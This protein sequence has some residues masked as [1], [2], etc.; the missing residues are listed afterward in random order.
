MELIEANQHYAFIRKEN[1]NES[2]VST[3]H[4]A[5]Y[6]DRSILDDV[7]TVRRKDMEDS[8]VGGKDIDDS[9]IIYD[10][11]EKSLNEGSSISEHNTTIEEADNIHNEN[12]DNS[13]MA[14]EGEGLLRRSQR[15]RRPPNRYDP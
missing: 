7:N 12:T 8:T 9:N 13:D 5:P 15:E 4:L 6:G 2:T 11:Q 3:K 1:G 14:V 10:E